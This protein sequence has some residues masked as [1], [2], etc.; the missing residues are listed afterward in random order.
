[1]TADLTSA[2]DPDR[3]LLIATYQVERAADTPQVQRNLTIASLTFVY[4]AAIAA[5]VTG[6]GPV[7]LALLLVL[8]LPAIGL[9]NYL[10]MNLADLLAHNWYIQRLERRLT[11][12]QPSTHVTAYRFPYWQRYTD[13]IWNPKVGVPQFK[14]IAILWPL[15]C[16]GTVFAFVIV[17]MVMCF[18]QADSTWSI[19][20]CALF[21]IG[22]AAMLGLGVNALWFGLPRLQRDFLR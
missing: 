1:M 8:P 14:A 21:S 15:M 16:L 5:L 7:P 4:I 18:R 11:A 19:V 17:L 12:Q 22:Y 3:D 20:A 9:L 2:D 13:R 10:I 6:E